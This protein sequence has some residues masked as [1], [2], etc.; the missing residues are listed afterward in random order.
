MILPLPPSSSSP[1]PPPASAS[2][3]RAGASVLPGWQSSSASPSLAVLPPR[4][5]SAPPPYNVQHYVTIMTSDTCYVTHFFWMASCL[6][7]S[8]SSLRR[9]SLSSRACLRNS[10]KAARASSSARSASSACLFTAS[11]SV[12]NDFFAFE[13]FSISERFA[14]RRFRASSSALRASSCRF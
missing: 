12:S 9:A 11:M 1:L 6:R 3:P 8:C 13:C 2:A 5:A 14:S 10:N 7:R 4:A